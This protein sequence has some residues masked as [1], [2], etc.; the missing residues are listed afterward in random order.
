MTLCKCAEKK[1]KNKNKIEKKPENLQTTFLH[2]K[3]IKIEAFYTER[4]R[5][6]KHQTA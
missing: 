4:L 5:L 6:P 2:N 3:K 1:T